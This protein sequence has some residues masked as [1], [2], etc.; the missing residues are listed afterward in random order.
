MP[1]S[2]LKLQLTGRAMTAEMFWPLRSWWPDV[3]A[4]APRPRLA[5][6]S[7]VFWPVHDPNPHLAGEPALIVGRAWHNARSVLFLARISRASAQAPDYG[8]S[9]LHGSGSGIGPRRN[10]RQSG[11]SLHSGRAVTPYRLPF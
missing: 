3:G 11:W 10:Q 1:P 5:A 2:S 7:N 9:A 8:H 4:W 6:A